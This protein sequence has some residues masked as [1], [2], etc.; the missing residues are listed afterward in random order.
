[1]FK[2]H[3]G[4]CLLYKKNEAGD[5]NPIATGNVINYI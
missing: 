4:S 1:L 3:I 2:T 5:I